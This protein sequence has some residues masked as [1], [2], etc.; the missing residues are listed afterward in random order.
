M[1][2]VVRSISVA[3]L[4]SPAL[5]TFG[6]ADLVVVTPI[7]DNTI[8][9][10]NDDISNGAGARLFVGNT[11]NEVKRRALISFDVP[12]NIP[13]GS[14][15]NS[16]TLRMNLNRAPDGAGTNDVTLHRLLADW[17]EGT[18][19]ANGQEGEG[20]AATDG[21]AT[22]M[23][24]FYNTGNPSG[25]PAW[26]AQGGEGDYVV[27]ASAT[28]PVGGR[29]AY[30]I[31]SWSSTGMVS[32]VQAWVDTPHG[33][34]G[35]MI[36]G[37]ESGAKTA[38]RFDSREGT[39][40][41]ELP[42]L[43]ID[44]T[45]PA[46]TGACCF[47]DGSC[48]VMSSGDCATGGGTYQGNGT[49]CTPNPCPQPPAFGACCFEDGTCIETNETD[50]GL[51]SGIFEGDGTSCASV[52]CPIV[53]E[54]FVD[55]LPIPGIAQPV[56]GSVGGTA[57]YEIAMQQFEQQLHRD[58]PPTVVWGYAGD[59]LGPTIVAGTGMP[60]TVVWS[61]DLRYPT[62]ELR[63]NHYLAVDT[64]MHGPDHF[65]NTPQTVVHL[66]GGHVEQDSDGYPEHTFL[67]GES[68]TYH[69]PNNQL[70]G[71]LWYHDHAL[72]ITRLN[73]YMGLAGAYLLIDD[74]ESALGLPSGAYEVPLV[75]QD[76]SFNPDGTWKYPDSWQDH[77]FGDKILV[78]G[79]VWPYLVVDQGK[80]RFRVLNGSNSRVY[81]LALSTG[82]TFQQIGTDGGL[83]PAP[84]T[85]TNLL[86]ATGERADIIVDFSPYANGS[87][88]LLT[89]NAP[90]LYPG[91]A[92]DGVLTNIIKFVVTNQVG[93]TAVVPSSLRPLEV[94]QE[95]DSVV[96]REFV[97]Q[98][99]S[100][101]CAG[102]I[103]L[104]NDLLWDDITE[105]PVLGTTEVWSFIN[106]S[107]ISHP[108]HMHLV[109]FQVLDRQPFTVI[110]NEV[111]T[112][113]PRVPPPPNEAGWKDTARV[114]PGE[115]VRV[116]AR[117]ENY[118]GLFAYHCHI[119]EHEDHEMMR[120][121]RTIPPPAITDFIQAGSN[122][123]ITF[124]SASN[125]PYRLYSS[126]NLVG[127]TWTTAASNIVGDASSTLVV[128]P[129]D[130]NAVEAAFTVE[131][132]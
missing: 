35:W 106:R 108:M 40:P 15:V 48:V 4:L 2:N 79:M 50:C 26:S 95:S 12:S 62:G 120:Q 69:Y 45:P 43:E 31:H 7:K 24:T 37:E 91:S 44:F 3:I 51:L 121:F 59:Y 93:H 105:Y 25:S 9:E 42:E 77:F 75:I 89:N 55:P 103:W 66:H 38:K 61:N 98:K 53:L 128:Q 102:Q 110:S 74:V 8:Y 117:F 94:L 109:M 83:L 131:S 90:V 64:C 113:G 21:D 116:I 6:L 112:T 47:N 81:D 132:E 70:P 86:L 73:V 100:D 67:P 10:P 85:L 32:D 57:T 13:V 49:E 115:I 14:T 17:G 36:K 71:T 124:Q 63:T 41:P 78:N 52:E 119:L 28:T 23:Y 101:P 80:Y 58:L 129:V 1:I 88:I 87:E 76:R 65:G 123:E 118:L 125:A 19:N 92:G 5:A 30:G 39:D 46:S 72:G 99:A 82:D 111:V 114:D 97:L 16:A 60:V 54:P 68:A 130:T 34:Y 96:E 107:G 20:R 122:L 126:S 127:G 18:S 104:I 22:W 56:S 11:D 84:V 27:S 33:N 29:E